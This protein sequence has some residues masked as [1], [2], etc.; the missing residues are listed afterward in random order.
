M[1]TF[2]VQQV[3]SAQGTSYL[4]VT[5]STVQSQSTSQQPQQQTTVTLPA[6]LVAATL[7]PTAT[8]LPSTSRSQTPTQISLVPASTPTPVT[9]TISAVQVIFC[10]L[11]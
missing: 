4:Q 8:T 9:A 2:Q 5:P 11:T 10:L 1:L 7:R 3:T 6:S